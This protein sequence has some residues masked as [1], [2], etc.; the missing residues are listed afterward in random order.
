M[1]LATLILYAQSIEESKLGRISRNLKRSGSID[2][3]QPR[4]KKWAQTQE[5]PNAPKVK[6]D[7]GGGSQNGKPTCVTCGKKYYGK[8]LRGTERCFGCGRDGHKVRDCPNRDG[9]KV[10]PNVS[11]QT[12]CF[13]AL[14]A[15]GETPDE[16]DD[17]IGKSISF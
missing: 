5:G 8:C 16:S 12:R 10:P 13:Y 4:F 11:V 15:R 6:F 3:G 9:K 1:T 2:Q 7:K 17:Y 14:R